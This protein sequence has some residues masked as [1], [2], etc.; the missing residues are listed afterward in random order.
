MSILIVDDSPDQQ[1]LLSA[2]LKKAGHR[3]VV[4]A[5]SAAIAYGHLG[6][7]GHATAPSTAPIDLI[8]MD[9][10]MP[11][12]DGVAATHHIK[13]LEHLRDIPIIVVTAKT[14]LDNLQ[15]AFTAGAMDFITKP[16]NSVELLARVK[17]AL[18]LKQEMDCRKS[19]EQELRRS[20]EELQR[21]LREVKVLKGL[22]PICASC[23]KIR[24]DQGFWQQLEEYIQQH[25]EAEFSH[26]LCT[27]C[28]KKLYPGVYTA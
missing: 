12:T 14:D 15:A 18:T 24:N 8:L 9:C 25:S 1:I 27:P 11:G 5:D 19:R 20:N 7:S 17:S 13:S 21:A 3:D 22:V 10:L 2:I 23:K 26:G 6:L 4:V 16:V 28:I